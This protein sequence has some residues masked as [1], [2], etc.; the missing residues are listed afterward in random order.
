MTT[1][2]GTITGVMYEYAPENM[3]SAA[4]FEALLKAKREI[5]AAWKVLNRIDNGIFATPYKSIAPAINTLHTMLKQWQ[6]AYSESVQRADKFEK[7]LSETKRLLTDTKSAYMEVGELLQAKQCELALARS[8]Y[9]ET[10]KLLF[11]ARAECAS[12]VNRAECNRRELEAARDECA[13]LQADN[14]WLRRFGAAPEASAQEIVRLQRELDATRDALEAVARS[15]N[16][17]Q[18]INA[19]LHVEIAKYGREKDEMRNQLEKENRMLRYERD[20][21]RQGH[22]ICGAKAKELSAKCAKLE[23]RCQKLRSAMFK[24]EETYESTAALHAIAYWAIVHDDE[25]IK[26]GQQCGAS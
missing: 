12:A 8:A 24:V 21:A 9:R 3:M 13:K 16:D 7:E 18:K 15:N 23:L 4:D 20:G 11:E 17:W 14:D 2:S 22:D 1:F 26:A 6:E 25:L 5:D 10:E 19:K